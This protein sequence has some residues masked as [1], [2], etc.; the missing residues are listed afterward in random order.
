MATLSAP[1]CSVVSYITTGSAMFHPAGAKIEFCL[2]LKFLQW[3]RAGEQPPLPHWDPSTLNPPSEIKRYF[4]PEGTWAFQVQKVI[5]RLSKRGSKFVQPLPDVQLLP[6]APCH[7]HIWA[8][9]AGHPS[10]SSLGRICGLI[11]APCSSLCSLWIHTCLKDTGSG[12]TC[13][14][15]I[16]QA[17]WPPIIHIFGAL[18][19]GSQG[20][21]PTAHHC[22]GWEGLTQVE[23]GLM[24]FSSKFCCRKLP[25]VP[26]NSLQ[27]KEMKTFTQVPALGS[28]RRSVDNDRNGR[29]KWGVSSASINNKNKTS[30]KWG[31]VPVWKPGLELLTSSLTPLQAPWKVF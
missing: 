2:R 16:S 24:C 6:V 11:F 25:E 17:T 20:F 7:A 21:I 18:R 9:N 31:I 1:T 13:L 27:S 26:K 10:E 3:G 4:V 29:T 23:S 14:G 19:E 30:V 5:I 22:Q 12:I 8:G 28:L 15:T